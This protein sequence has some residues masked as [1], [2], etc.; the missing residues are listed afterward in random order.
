MT[1]TKEDIT[2]LI[3]RSFKRTVSD[4]GEDDRI[5]VLNL[6]N[7]LLDGLEFMEHFRN[8]TTSS[9]NM[10]DDNISMH[11]A[12]GRVYNALI[13]DDILLMKD[14]VV[15]DERYLMHLPNIGYSSIQY[16]KSILTPINLSLGMKL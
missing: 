8:K 12:D 15:K 10:L 7:N 13:N 2:L 14:L 3:E 6:K 4:Y 1:Y 5:A 11:I 16:I 9:V